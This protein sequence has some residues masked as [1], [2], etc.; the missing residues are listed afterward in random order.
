MSR[1]RAAIVWLLETADTRLGH[2][3]ACGLL[4]ARLYIGYQA[5]RDTF[6]LTLPS[7]TYRLYWW[8]RGPCVCSSPGPD[9]DEASDG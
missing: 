7:P 9:V 8:A 3:W 4:N 5:D 2:P 1:I 6:R